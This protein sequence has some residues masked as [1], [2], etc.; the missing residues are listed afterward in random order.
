M[1]EAPPDRD[2]IR[3]KA[4]QRAEQ[5]N[6]RA[7]PESTPE[8]DGPAPEPVP[9]TNLQ[10]LQQLLR[11]GHLTPGQAV[12]ARRMFTAVRQYLNDNPKDAA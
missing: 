9:T 11:L 10:A 2:T 6:L 8:T 1:S 12:S 5:M 4:R 7:R 3:R